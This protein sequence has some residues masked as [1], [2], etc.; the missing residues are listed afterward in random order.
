MVQF[1]VPILAALVG[2]LPGVCWMPPV[3]QQVVDLFRQPACVW[4]PGNRGLKYGTDAGTPVRAVAAG[5]V[6]FSGSVVGTGYVVVRH[7][8]GIRATYGNI[9]GTTLAEGDIVAARAVIGFA[10]GTVH[11]GLR[12]G[13]RYLDPALFI[14]RMVHRARLVPL[15][16]SPPRP[17]PPPRLRCSGATPG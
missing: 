15:D 9:T 3:E 2:A 6:T 8:D 1:L 11:F 14:G 4:C 7:A 12:E 17:A 10:A 5:T 16:G 13:D